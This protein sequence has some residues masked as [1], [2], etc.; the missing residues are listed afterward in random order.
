L[1][2]IARIA[3]VGFISGDPLALPLLC[4]FTLS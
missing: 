2:L 4:D 3:V 1:Y